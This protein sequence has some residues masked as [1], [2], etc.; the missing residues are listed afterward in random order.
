MNASQY[1][2]L[3]A[4]LCGHMG[5]A[6]WQ[7]VTQSGHIEMDGHTI[8]LMRDEAASDG[9]LSIY[10][11]L[12]PVYEARDPGILRRM[13]VANLERR[14]PITGAFGLHPQTGEAVYHFSW[15]PCGPASELA[16]HLAG[17]LRDIPDR[18]EQM[19]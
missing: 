10:I 6:E 12:G 15:R 18:L 2:Q 13:L 7:Q 3:V 8:G 19:K 16:D 11:D 5:I 14:G 17:A 9:G 4:E 1:E